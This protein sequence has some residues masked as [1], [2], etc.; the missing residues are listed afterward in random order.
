MCNASETFVVLSVW[1]IAFLNN[2]I[3]T[4]DQ[5][6]QGVCKWRDRIVF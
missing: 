4:V 2:V 3:I 1:V 6:L 5:E